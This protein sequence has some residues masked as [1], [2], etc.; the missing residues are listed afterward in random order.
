MKKAIIYARA[1]ANLAD[2]SL[3]SIT[4]QT[5]SCK[6]FAEEND[7][8]IVG[9]YSDIILSG[10]E[11]DYPAWNSIL[12][13]RKPIFD[14]VLIY[15]PDRI[16]R[17]CKQLCKDRRCLH[18]KGILI[19]SVANP[20]FNENEDLYVCLIANERNDTIYCFNTY[21]YTIYCFFVSIGLYASPPSSV[22]CSI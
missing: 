2:F 16:G 8:K 1:K 14:T 4:A 5:L 15:E 10:A 9:L 21:F 19:V 20:L 17:N 13:I 6:K 12:R 18:N 3:V 11:P 22:S 7:I